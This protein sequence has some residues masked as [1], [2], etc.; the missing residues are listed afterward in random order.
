MGKS[1]PRDTKALPRDTNVWSRD[2][3]KKPICICPFHVFVDCSVCKHHFANRNLSLWHYINPKM[4]KFDQ[5]VLWQNL[6]F[7]DHYQLKFYFRHDFI[8]GEQH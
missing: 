3:E 8:D 7:I 1:W 4:Y 2:R 6:T 5:R